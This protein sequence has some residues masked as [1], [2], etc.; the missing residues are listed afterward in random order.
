MLDKHFNLEL[1]TPNFL[2]IPFFLKLEKEEMKE[3]FLS[4]R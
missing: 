1:Y 3:Y 4:Q 2:L